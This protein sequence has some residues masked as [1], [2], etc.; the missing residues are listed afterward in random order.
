MTK[1]V[2]RYLVDI[3]ADGSDKEI[4]TKE[5]LFEFATNQTY[6]W[7]EENLLQATDENGNVNNKYSEAI[8]I[9]NKI[10]EENYKIKSLKEINL[11][12]SL[13]A[14]TIPFEEIYI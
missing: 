13:P 7:Y 11:L 4:M 6:E 14:T 12:F 5:K 3:Y 10:I 1:K 2:K 9:A 8:S